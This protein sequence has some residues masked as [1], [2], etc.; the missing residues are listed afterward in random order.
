MA[1][2]YTIEAVFRTRSGRVGQLHLTA[3]DVAAAAFLDPSGQGDLIL[4][5][6]E[7]KIIQMLYSGTPATTTTATVWIN[8]QN[9][10][11]VLVGAANAPG[12]VTPQINERTS[13]YVPAGGK[14]RFV[15]V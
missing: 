6:E 12:A 14:I 8:G 1:T 7:A 3:S 4:A 11:V 15:Q 13:I 10:G 5:G 9:T 2:P